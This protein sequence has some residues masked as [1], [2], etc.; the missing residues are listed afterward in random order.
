MFEQYGHNRLFLFNQFRG[1]AT[2]FSIYK[3]FMAFPINVN[4]YTRDQVLYLRFDQENYDDN[5][6]FNKALHTDIPEES[7]FTHD[8]LDCNFDLRWNNP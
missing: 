2:Y 5:L 4:E 8:D 6:I 1:H 3:K 7:I